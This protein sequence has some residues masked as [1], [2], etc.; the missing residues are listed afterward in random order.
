MRV[1]LWVVR[2]KVSDDQVPTRS[3]RRLSDIHKSWPALVILAAD[4]S[5]EAHY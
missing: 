2:Y 3:K 1:E 5:F 4:S